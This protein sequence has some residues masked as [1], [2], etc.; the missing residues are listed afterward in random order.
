MRE[1][2]ARRFKE[3]RESLNLSQGDFAD[4]TGLSRP[5]ISLYESG[6]RIPDIVIL[7]RICKVTGCSPAFLMGYSDAMKDE[8]MAAM[9][10][11][12][13]TEAAVEKL[14]HDKELSEF[15][16][17]LVCHE[18]FE[19]LGDKAITGK[20][21]H[22]MSLH[23]K[24]ED[25]FFFEYYRDAEKKFAQILED[26]MLKKMDTESVSSKTATDFNG[27]Y[28]EYVNIKNYKSDKLKNELANL[29]RSGSS[30]SNDT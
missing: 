25:V 22:N 10:Q 15:V 9:T 6:N 24:R 4:K 14:M 18:D 29:L 1:T 17:D 12:G 28:D 2:F 5:T 30:S 19:S 11:T 8:N 7:D 13:L 3:L 20:I 26:Y 16:S 23:A 27:F 21:L